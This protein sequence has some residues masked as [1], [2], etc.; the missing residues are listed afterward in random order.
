MAGCTP[1]AEQH[2]DS[3]KSATPAQSPVER[4]KYLVTV[5]GC[6]DCHT[7]KSFANGAPEPDMARQLSGNPQADKVAKVPAS[8]I[9][10]KTSPHGLAPGASASQ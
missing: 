9:G 4:G 8:L 1:A 10:P 3:A 2:T 6:H 5:G 7:P